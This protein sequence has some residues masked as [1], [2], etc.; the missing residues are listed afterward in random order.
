MTALM[1]VSGI[2][3]IGGLV[4]WIFTS[5]ALRKM[6]SIKL[7]QGKLEN[8]ADKEPAAKDIIPFLR[9]TN[10]WNSDSKG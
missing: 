8:A 6:H 9:I 1:I 7:V 4:T 10:E 5:L 3:I 2:L